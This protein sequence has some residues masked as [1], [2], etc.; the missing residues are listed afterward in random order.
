MKPKQPIR[1]DSKTPTPAVM[2]R[3][4]KKGQTPKK[5]R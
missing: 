4:Q 3:E 2:M 5:A 1:P